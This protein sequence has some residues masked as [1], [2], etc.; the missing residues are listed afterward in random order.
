MQIMADKGLV[1]RDT[2]QRTHV[3]TAA[4]EEH[5]V[6]S[7]LLSSFLHAAYRGSTKSLVMQALGDHKA[8]K[9]ELAEIKAL[10][11][12]LEEKS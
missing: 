1:I 6:Q 11:S 10:I 9:E 4:I 7:S 12:K 3:Y 8:S 5:D 2:S